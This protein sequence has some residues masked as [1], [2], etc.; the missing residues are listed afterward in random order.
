MQVK[1]WAKTTSDAQP[2]I[3]V[4]EHMKKV[5][6]VACVLAQANPELLSRFQM[7]VAEVGAL[8]ALHDL[9]KISPGF[10]RK[11]KVWLESSGVLD[12]ARRWTWDTTM[13]ADHGAVT[14]AVV[15]RF[16][17][18]TGMK[19]R[20]AKY[21]AAVLGG[22]HGRLQWPSDRGFKPNKEI[23]E[24]NSG[25]D[26]DGERNAAARA[27]S[28]LFNAK[29]DDLLFDEDTPGL[30]WLAGLTSVADWI[31]SDETLFPPEGDAPVADAAD[32]AA[33]AVAA[34]GLVAPD[35]IAGSSFHDLFHD[36]A[37]PETQF[38]PNDMQLAAKS[39]ITGPGVYVIEAP[40][41]MGKTEAALW[42]AYELM[43]NCKARGIYFALPTQATSNRM[44]RRMA[45]FVTRIARRAQPAG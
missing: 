27:V 35:V 15:Q 3:S 2:G 36:T 25:I 19:R 40:M 6:A 18:S 28:E 41:G 31:G 20:S 10:Q 30:W 29:L 9:G 33:E 34:I 43:V 17:T 44:H 1:F 14:H 8:A 12:V 45:D 5:G 24:E 16:L 22:H 39:A 38:A 23:S 13:E 21:L 4:F 7:G 37:H 11:C 42:A 26:W 32:I